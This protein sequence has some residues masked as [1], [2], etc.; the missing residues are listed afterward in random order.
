MALSPR[1]APP[2]GA[3]PQ[4]GERGL[5]SMRLVLPM[6]ASIALVS[7]VDIP[8]DPERTEALVRE[9]GVVRLGWVSGAAPDRQAME[10]LQRIADRTNA[11]IERRMGESEAILSDLRDGKLDLAYGHFPQ[12]TPWSTEVH[13]GDALGWRAKP[14][15]HQHVPRFA[16]RNGENGWIMLVDRA[17]RP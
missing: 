17:S 7:C 4:V 5:E 9:T 14:P 15:K 13:F 10:A 6:L 16:M 3:E 11:R 12:S 1:S 2:I 8:R